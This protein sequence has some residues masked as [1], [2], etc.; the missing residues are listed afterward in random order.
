MHTG[1]LEW[2]YDWYGEYPLQD[3]I[4]PVGVSWGFGKVIRGGLPDDKI[5]SFDHPLE[6]YTRSA[7]RASL[8][9]AFEGLIQK[10][11]SKLLKTERN[12]DQFMPGLTGILYDDAVMKR[13]LALWRVLNLNSDD[14]DWKNLNDWSVRW[15]GSIYAPASG[16]INFHTEADNGI[17]IK[18]AGQIVVDG[19]GPHEARQG[20]FNMELGKKYPIEVFYFKDM[21]ESYMRIY[22]SWDGQ[23]KT[24][25]PS[26][27][28]E[29]NRQ[30]HDLMEST[31]YAAVAAKV[32]APSIGF[33]IVQANFPATRFLSYEAVQ[34]MQGIKQNMP[35]VD[36]GPNLNKPYFRKRHLL[37][38]P[39]ENSEKGTIEAAGLHYTFYRHIHDP[40]FAVCN[41]GDLLAVLFTSTYEDEPEVSLLAVRLRYGADQWD[42]PTPFID[43]ADVNDVA[44]MLWND[45]G[46]LNFYFGNIH[47]DSAYPFQWTT[48][49]DNGATW[50]DVNY[51]NFAG[52]V[53]PH[54]AQPINS[55]FRDKNEIVYVAC[56]GL[57]ATSVLYTSPDDGKTWYDHMGRSGGRHTSFVQLKN[58]KIL[59]MGG[60]HSDI[61]GYMPQSIS[62]DGGKTWEIS[63][64]PFP[65]QGTNQRPTIT[66]LA[67]G[68]LFMAGDFQRIDGFQPTSIK[69]RG[70]YAALSSDEG[71]SWLIKK[72]PGG[73]LHES[74][75]IRNTMR[76]ETLGYSVAQQAPNGMIHLIATMTH[77]CLHYEFN[78]AWIL[79]DSQI[80]DD[81][82]S[83]LM[84]PMTTEMSYVNIYDEKYAD[85]QL[86]LIY[87][88]GRGDDDRILLH[89][90]ETWYYPD[91]KKQYE[92]T[93]HLG[94]KVGLESYWNLKE[95]KIWEWEH[96]KNGRSQWTQWWANGT[97]K[98]ESNWIGKVCN[99]PAKTWDYQGN[100]NT[101][102]VFKNGGILN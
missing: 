64:T 28:L 45:N 73:Q 93:Y 16:K 48:S 7:N 56:D 15:Q 66:R 94:R 86:R 20:S 4:D 49:V 51:P 70:S 36:K 57:G 102:V 12:Y 14:L 41:N 44:P 79:A 33:R 80:R 53:G 30:D 35:G 11:A 26:D 71:K 52:A 61:D 59:G 10:D 47:L 5:L 46:K 92:V 58:G 95:V 25:I 62:S 91:G 18:I 38:I 22:W 23:N 83:N 1:V 43:H 69:Q 19:W 37:P 29:H 54:T 96:Q 85:G 21:G 39:P 99:G 40:G 6:Y 9:P 34:V 55:A 3:Q 32:R 67:S 63:K 101:D 72:I 2:C 89:G 90:K 77:P 87:H 82:D 84:A 88:T 17:R 27:A 75:D 74:I 98:A 60:K 13:P 97:K 50:D 31:F 78:E 65:A 81:S 8:G 24:D 100:L 76:G 68:R 42:M